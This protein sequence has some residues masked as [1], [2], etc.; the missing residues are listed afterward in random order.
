M[1]VIDKYAYT[2][3]L[4]KLNP[5]IKVLLSLFFLLVSL[6]FKSVYLH[7]FIIALI[8]LSIVLI[9]K[10]ELLKYLKLLSIPFSFLTISIIITLM[11]ITPDKGTLTHSVH[12]F[13]LYI[14]ISPDTVRMSIQI[15][16]RSVSCLVCVY[17]CM[18]TTPFNQLIYVMKRAHI[19]NL[20]IELSMLTYRFIFIFL[21]EFIDIY[22]SQELRF[23]YINV[24]NS[25]RSLGFLVSLLYTRLIKRYEDMSVSLDIKLYDG[26]FH[27]VEVEDV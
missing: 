20:F 15:F 13:N 26:E 27:I 21:E 3:A 2:N 23:G 8:S 11:S 25:Y 1:L 22:K 18:L 24:R 9:A 12:I 7:C 5:N 4:T 16:F 17:F 6:I 19:P 14:G 10:I